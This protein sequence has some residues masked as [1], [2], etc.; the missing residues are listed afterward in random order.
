MAGSSS[1]RIGLA[2]EAFVVGS[3]GDGGVLGANVSPA[4]VGPVVGLGLGLVG[5]VGNKVRLL[6]GL[7]AGNAVG[8]DVPPTLLAARVGSEVG[9]FAAV[10]FCVGSDVGKSVGRAVGSGV[11]SA[12]GSPVG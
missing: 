4:L 1:A 9:L 6:V 3:G 2:V 7:A 8:A 5:L 12:V 11:G 10:T